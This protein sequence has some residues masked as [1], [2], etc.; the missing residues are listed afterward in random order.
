VQKRFA[1]AALTVFAASAQT[2]SAPLDPARRAFNAGRFAEAARLFENARTRDKACEI[3]L[4]LGMARYRLHQVDDALIAFQEAANC[5]P[6]LTLAWI[7]LGEAYAERGNDVEALSAYERAL[8]H[9]PENIV[10]LRGAAALCIRAK[11]TARAVALLE[12]LTKKERA[13]ADAHAE[14][15]AAYFGT[16]N[17]DAAETE[18]ARALEINPKASGAMLGQA[19]V[20]V[21]KGEEQ[22][23]VPLLQQ[24]IRATPKAYEPRY[25]LGTAY[26]RMNRFAEAAAELERAIQLGATEPE[27]CYHLARAYGG[28]GQAE[29]RTA[30]L[31]KFA[32]LSRQAKADTEA[33][34]EAA[35]M[36][37]QAKLI[38]ESGDLAGALKLVEQARDLRPQDD[39]ILFR[40]ASLDYDL[41]R[42][43]Q[44]RDAIEEAT[45]LAPSEWVYRLLAG[46]I[47]GR[48]GRLENA[49][50]S[51]DLAIRLNPS[52]ADAHNALGE[53][54]LRL[55][56]VKSAEASF[57][58]AAELDPAQPVYR[59]NLE[60][61]RKAGAK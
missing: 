26:N 55:G 32:A 11:L 50:R 36:V 61:A 3:P 41:A 42:Y 53:V 37:E 30:A 14:L 21:R 45:A 5:D 56:D 29:K 51:L 15:G 9:E 4:Y 43:D 40:L 58:K 16:G 12:V 57:Q 31:A 23:A 39:T 59:A 48:S 6:K 18:F 54:A 22:Q 1:A 10:A 7:A 52:A 44:A 33:R 24:V 2:S 28:L 25:V 20:L 8:S 19:N 46:L 17:I 38:V 35:K 27:V 47:E 34:R 49:R 60:L 13:D